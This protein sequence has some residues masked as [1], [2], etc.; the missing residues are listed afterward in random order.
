[1][2]IKEIFKYTL[3]GS[4]SILSSCTSMLDV[5]PT[6]I[7]TTESYWKKEDDANGVLTG[8]YAKLRT[9]TEINLYLLGE[10]RSETLEWGKLVGDSYNRYHQNN[11]SPDVAGPSWLGW[12]S[13]VNDANLLLKY[14]P[15]IR[16]TNE[17]VKNNILAQAYTMR[18][19]AYYVMTRS[20]GDLII[21]LEPTEGYNPETLYLERSAQSTVFELIKDDIEKAQSLYGNNTLPS[22]RFKWSLPGL[23]ALKAD[24][25]LW[26]GKRMGGGAA[27]FEIALKSCEE[28]EKS[29]VQLLDNYGDIFAYGN[30][31]NK[32]IITAVRFDYL[33]STVDNFYY[34][35]YIPTYIVP[36]N[37]D[38]ATL[39]TIGV[40][41]GNIILSPSEILRNNFTKDDTRK[42]PSIL[43]IYTTTG[44][45]KSF[46][47][48]IVMK[49]SGVV[50]SGARKFAT[51]V[52]IYRFA[53]VLLM[54]AEAKNALNLDPSIEINKVRAR[55]YKAKA[56]DYLFVNGTKEAND[57]EILKERMLELAFECKRWWDL[58]RFDKA[59]EKVPSL[60]GKS[61]KKHL[62]LFPIGNSVLSLEP[63]VKQNNGYEL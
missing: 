3:V 12:Y 29:D 46:F 34:N 2:K 6:S 39:S 1:M 44:G 5:D 56:N 50:N 30:K 53:D 58:V 40:P 47:G 26:T 21:R 43:E 10:S 32:E 48:S 25:Y 63:K 59:Y 42:D 31:G 9:E 13:I 60:N 22:G 28:V 4:F 35:M 38:A 7:I 27:D 37:T 20:W 36:N 62:M 57:E 23:Y 18:A 17:E 45:V 14:V 19:F 51:D 52:A 8:M 11:L 33:E 61:D 49:G 54:K 16:F 55:A 41:G 24:V 15:A